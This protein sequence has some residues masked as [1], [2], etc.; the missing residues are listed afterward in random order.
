MTKKIFTGK[1]REGCKYGGE[2]TAVFNREY[3]T[4]LTYCLSANELVLLC[5]YI[6][7]RSG[8]YVKEL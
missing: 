7:L 3:H 2:L 8:I 5:S 6:G 4:N 1:E